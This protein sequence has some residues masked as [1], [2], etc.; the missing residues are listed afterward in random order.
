M[1]YDD[2]IDFDHIVHGTIDYANDCDSSWH[3]TQ[4]F[5]DINA[6]GATWLI[7]GNQLLPPFL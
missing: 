2:G 4:G 3:P 7:N 1:K 5:L 6:P